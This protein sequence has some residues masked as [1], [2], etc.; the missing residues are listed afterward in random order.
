MVEHRIL[1]NTFS[2]KAG[3]I[4]LIHLLFLPLF[5]NSEAK[6]EPSNQPTSQPN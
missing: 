1:Y 3:I 5:F 6:T 4:E 2:L